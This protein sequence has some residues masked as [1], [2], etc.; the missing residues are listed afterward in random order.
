MVGILILGKRGTL[1]TTFWKRYTRLSLLYSKNRQ[2]LKQR[3]VVGLIRNSGSAADEAPQSPD[4]AMTG[5]LHGT[6]SVLSLCPDSIW[7]PD[8]LI[9]F[10]TSQ[11]TTMPTWGGLVEGLCSH[12]F[13]RP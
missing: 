9:Q 5:L 4:A 7:Q 6:V 2:I 8:I 11:F 1:V 12:S 3:Q 13:S 10:R